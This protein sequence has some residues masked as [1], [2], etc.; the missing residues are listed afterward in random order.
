M[1]NDHIFELLDFGILPLACNCSGRIRSR[2][3]PVGLSIHNKRFYY[4]GNFSQTFMSIGLSIRNK[5]LGQLYSDL[6]AGFQSNELGNKCSTKFVRKKQTINIFEWCFRALIKYLVLKSL[7][8]KIGVKLC[9]YYAQF[10]LL[11][12]YIN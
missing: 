11:I 12:S 3:L 5:I 2:S 1:A 8:L 7:S 9:S 10:V 4:S 6:Y